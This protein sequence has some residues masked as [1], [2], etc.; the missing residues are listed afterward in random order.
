MTLRCASSSGGIDS[1]VYANCKCKC[2]AK[3]TRVSWLMALPA[4]LAWSLAYHEFFLI[5]VVAEFCSGKPQTVLMSEDRKSP[6]S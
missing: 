2:S 5:I 4:W 3:I 6:A 1:I